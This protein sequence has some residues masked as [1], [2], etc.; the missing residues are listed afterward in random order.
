MKNLINR[1]IYLL[2]A[3]T[4]PL[5]LPAASVADS[6]IVVKADRLHVGNGTVIENG[7][8]LIESG[9]IVAVG[10]GLTVPDGAKTIDVKNGAITPGLIDAH[11]QIDPTGRTI[12]RAAGG[13]GT[14]ESE[15]EHGGHLSGSA[16]NV[17]REIFESH[18]HHVHS[19]GFDCC[20]STCPLSLQHVEEVKCPVCGFPDVAPAFR[21][22]SAGAA[23][24]SFR[25]TDVESSS[26][27][28]PETRVIDALDL[29]SPDFDRLLR[30]GVTTVYVSP[31]PAAV[32][33]SQGAVVRTGGPVGDRVDREADAVLAAMGTDPSWRGFSNRRPWR[34]N[35]NFYARRPTT[36]MGVA[37]VFRK[38]FYDAQRHEAG[39]EVSGADAPTEP[40]MRVLAKILKGE[41]PL[42]IQARMQHDILTALRLADEFG[43]RFTLVE[44][45]EAYRCLDELKSTS[46]P[47]V[48]GPIYVTAPGARAGTFEVNEARL[49]TLRALLDAEIPTALTAHELRDE[50]GLSRQAMYAL[51]YGV[52]KDEVTRLVTEMPAKLLGLADEIGTI[53]PGKRADLVLWNGEPFNGVSKPAVVLIDGK[54]VLDQRPG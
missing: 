45:T 46:T 16:I 34:T 36:R 33:S 24:T 49:H 53:E 6:P 10:P 42:R 30:D 3:L 27:T 51:R 20:G 12:I 18:D 11:A 4:L 47:V 15:D 31:D 48:Y 22:T 26:E 28:I 9:R 23:G 21:P 19:P 43:L 44:G 5:S 38:A 32:I 1:S 8:V 7:W 25:P 52:S 2:C 41:I 13:R 37:W 54:I 40:A 14:P 50:A 17:A 39:L 29:R 35:V